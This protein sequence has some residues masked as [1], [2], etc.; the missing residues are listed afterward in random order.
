MW[1]WYCYK[2]TIEDVSDVLEI[3]NITQESV[4]DLKSPRLLKECASVLAKP[5]SICFNR[6]LQQGYFPS[7]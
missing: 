2:I 6:S 3:L 5:I 4:S 7:F 1:P